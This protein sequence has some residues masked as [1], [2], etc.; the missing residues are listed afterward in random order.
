MTQL[1]KIILIRVPWEFNSVKFPKYSQ[2]NHSLE[3]I[4]P[5]NRCQLTEGTY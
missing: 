2:K 3:L 4:L 1:L 5:L